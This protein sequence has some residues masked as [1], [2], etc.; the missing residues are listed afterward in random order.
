LLRF[1]GILRTFEQY[2]NM[3]TERKLNNID[4]EAAVVIM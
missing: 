3:S 1:G 2:V 4:P